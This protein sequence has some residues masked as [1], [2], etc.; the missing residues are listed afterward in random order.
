MSV[1]QRVPDGVE[2]VTLGP[3]PRVV[4]PG[5][6]ITVAFQVRNWTSQP[7][8]YRSEISPPPGWKVLTSESPYAV[9]GNGQEVRLVTVIVPAGAVS[10]EYTLEYRVFDE[11]NILLTAR[12]SLPV[13]VN[14]VRALELRLVESSRFVAAGEGYASV[15][16]VSNRGNVTVAVTLRSWSVT[17]F[18]ASLDSTFIHL[19]ARESRRVTVTVATGA[20]HGERIK[21]YN[22]LVAAVEGDSSVSAT[23]SSSTDVVSGAPSDIEPAISF[24]VTSTFRLGGRESLGALQGEAWGFGSLRQD[25]TGRLE[26]MV[27]TPD[28]QSVTFLGARDEYRV[29][30]STGT[31]GMYAGDMTYALTPLTESGRQA[32]GLGGSIDVN[33]VFAGGF[34]NRTRFYVPVLSEQAAFLG[35]RVAETAELSANYIRKNDV[36][37][38]DLVSLRGV[39]HPL[40]RGDVDFEYGRDLHARG[41]NDAFA[42]HAVG[43]EE[44]IGYDARYVRAQP[45]F[46]GYYRDV[47]FFSAN[48]IVNPAGNIWFEGLARNERR[49]LDLDTVLSIAPHSQYYQFGAGYHNWIYLGI[50]ATSIQDEMPRAV[51]DQH[52]LTAILRGGYEFPF[53]SAQGTMEI[54]SARENVLGTRGSYY[55]YGLSLSANPSPSLSIGGSG[56]YL[57]EPILFSGTTMDQYSGTLN[58]SWTFTE[59]TQF[60]LNT[61]ASRVTTSPEVTY[62]SIDASLT[63]V[64]P[65]GH[66]IGLRGR[67]SSTS[68]FVSV[69]EFAYI[70]EYSI[71]LQI[72]VPRSVPSGSLRGKV[73]DRTTGTGIPHAL[74]SAGTTTAI[75][76]G[77][78]DFHFPA[79][80][81]DLYPLRLDLGTVGLNMVQDPASPKEVT[82]SDGEEVTV[83]IALVPAASIV[84]R[85]IRCEYVNA[86]T[87]DSTQDT[88]ME[89]PGAG[90]MRVR[91][92]SG[93]NQLTRVAD[94]NGR[95]VF[96]EIVPGDWMLS[97]DLQDLPPLTFAERDSLAL[98]VLPGEKAEVSIRILPRKRRIN[99]IEVNVVRPAPAVPPKPTPRPE[100]KRRR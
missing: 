97:V 100:R 81:P 94:G 61:Y 87:A 55:R 45:E 72:P 33:G 19:T 62:V 18:P 4:Q 17:G 22:F 41:N 68:S 77:T 57:H 14:P 6:I 24:P 26:F 58:A 96:S 76:G 69:N 78:G 80:R 93:A 44:W 3:S 35:Y 95:F 83:A 82:V 51:T 79:L 86:L 25:R 2:V 32:F 75:T 47:G 46:G 31:A 66:R 89:V 60:L 28:L 42:M 20:S 34:V 13:R 39:M 30:Y 74:I 59:K 16:E 1:A 21:D 73:I 15:Y 88:L 48:V 84:G 12:A 8:R 53:L 64:L 11:S 38:S 54:G 90:G 67:Y 92:G 52:E 43:R 10:L 85:L 23:A 29:A 99:I 7:R 27:R 9:M 40:G 98:R 91:L 5:S 56:E 63:H 49:N 65:F 71:P 37:N 36:L 50:R 70:V